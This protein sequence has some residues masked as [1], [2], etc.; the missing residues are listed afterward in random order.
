APVNKELKKELQ[1]QQRLFQQIEEKIAKLKAEQ[2]QLEAA[3]A[4]PG[5]YGD[6]SKFLQTETAYK[7]ATTE[8]SALNAEYEKIFEK[9]VE[10]EE[11]SA[12]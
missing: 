2:Q 10:L 4:S 11:K 8:L 3:L 7:K 12:G 1:K 9:I 5:T 6:K